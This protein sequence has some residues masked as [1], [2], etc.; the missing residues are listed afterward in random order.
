MIGC[1]QGAHNT[2]FRAYLGETSNTLIAMLPP[3]KQRKS[4]IKNTNFF[5]AFGVGTVSLAVGQ[6]MLLCNDFS[7]CL[8]LNYIMIA[9]LIIG[10][11]VVAVQI[12]HL[13]QF[14]WPGYWI[15]M[16]S[17]VLAVVVLVLFRE[18][19]TDTIRGGRRCGINNLPVP[20]YVS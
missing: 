19:W 3:E 8:S 15:V 16:H 7:V 9:Q 20:A 2:L 4:H 1:Y 12:P 14:R 5:V 10:L 17:V 6:S 18:R 11:S 13:D